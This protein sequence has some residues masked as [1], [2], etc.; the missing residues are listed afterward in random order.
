MKDFKINYTPKGYSMNY[1]KFNY[2]KFKQNTVLQFKVSLDEI[3][4]QIWRRIQVPIDY[5]FWDLHVAI[6]DSMGW[7]DY[8]LHHFVIKDRRQKKD[9]RIGIPDFEMKDE[10][11]EIY[12][13]WELGITEFYTE[14]GQKTQY[15]YDY[16]DDW[17]HTVELEGYLKKEKKKYPLC[18]DGKRACPPEDCGGVPGYYNLIEVLKHPN[19]EEHDQMKQWAGN[20]NPGGFAKN[21][22]KFFDPFKRWENAFFE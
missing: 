3:R 15:I 20:W 19:H 16:G 11:Y 22:I 6:Q 14:I 2:S 17:I 1:Q 8:H 9:V 4:P 13:G 21:K 5:N 10:K 7:L 12:P 18:I